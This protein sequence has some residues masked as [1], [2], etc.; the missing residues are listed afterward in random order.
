MI[1]WKSSTINLSVSISVY[2]VETYMTRKPIRSFIYNTQRP[3]SPYLRFGV[4]SSILEIMNGWTAVILTPDLLSILISSANASVIP[5]EKYSL[6]VITLTN[7]GVYE[8]L[9][10]T[11]IFNS[12]PF[13]WGGAGTQL[14][15]FLLLIPNLCL[16]CWSE[17]SFHTNISTYFFS[18]HILSWSVK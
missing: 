11:I 12:F 1:T 14:L 3:L 9:I 7:I 18:F 17:K 8:I 4:T 6:S 16:V 5:N 15:S 13:T 10:Y 2:S